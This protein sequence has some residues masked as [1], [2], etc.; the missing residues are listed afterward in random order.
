MKNSE[1]SILPLIQDL[2]NPSAS[3]GWANRERMAFGERHDVDVG[4]A[5]A[6]IHHIAISNNVPLV[7]VAK[8]FSDLCRLLIIEFVPKAD[9]QVER[10][11]VTREDVFP[12][13]NETGFEQ[14]FN[15]YFTILSA[16][17]LGGS[18]RTLYLLKSKQDIN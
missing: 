12:D 14:A 11:L 1:H 18:E 10:L 17:K 9:S 5:L 3:I 8:F 7:S 4:M 13:Y 15:Q 2:T 6:I 16:E